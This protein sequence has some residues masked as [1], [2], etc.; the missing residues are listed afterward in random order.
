MSTDG[1]GAYNRHHWLGGGYDDFVE[2]FFAQMYSE[3]HSTRQREESAEWAHEVGPRVLA[4]CTSGRLGLEGA[5][6]TDLADLLARVRCP[7]LVVHGTEDRV[8]A[9]SDGAAFAEGSGGSLVL[10]EGGGHGLPA[11]DP[12]LADRESARLRRAGPG[13]APRPG[14]GSALLAVAG[15]RS[16]CPPP[17]GSGTPGA[18][19][20]IARELR[21][22]HPDLADRLARPAPRDRVLEAAGERVHPASALAG[23]RVAHIEARVPAS[24]TSTPSRRSAGWTRSSST[25]SWCF[26]DVR[27]GEPT[28]TS[29]SPT[30]PG[31]S[32]TTCTRTPS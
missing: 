27:R 16:S 32:T 3:P 24:T 1:W 17:S 30:R 18:T 13:A 11:R 31:R 8:R 2:F 12:V 15:R 7:V 21:E 23:Q 9:P 5:A 22:L 19:S 10:V 4:D 14:A 6:L 28:T 20:P 25:T 29:S 26:D